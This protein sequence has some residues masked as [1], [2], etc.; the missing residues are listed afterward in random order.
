M[1]VKA[2]RMAPFDQIGHQLLAKELQNKLDEYEELKWES[3]ELKINEIRLKLALTIARSLQT[4][5]LQVFNIMIMIS[6]RLLSI[7][8][9]N[10]ISEVGS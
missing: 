1:V 8:H 6:F 2:K 9:L 3:N 5:Q 4:A 7:F 10:T